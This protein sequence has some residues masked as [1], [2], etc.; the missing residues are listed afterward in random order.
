MNALVILRLVQQAD[1]MQ[2]MQ[3]TFDFISAAKIGVFKSIWWVCN[4]Q[5]HR[6]VLFKSTS[7]SMVSGSGFGLIRKCRGEFLSMEKVLFECFVCV[8]FFVLSG[9]NVFTSV[10]LASRT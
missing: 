6:S 2:Q 5:Y 8:S 1:M 4:W 3:H 7:C 9:V 10:F